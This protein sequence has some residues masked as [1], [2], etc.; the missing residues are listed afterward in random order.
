[1]SGYDWYIRCILA[2]K[3]F[4]NHK[5]CFW[6]GNTDRVEQGPAEPHG[7]GT[8]I[9]APFLGGVALCLMSTEGVGDMDGVQEKFAVGHGYVES[10]AGA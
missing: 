2:L 1:M 10:I 3:S 8:I 7:I 6:F 9:P 5:G 4:A